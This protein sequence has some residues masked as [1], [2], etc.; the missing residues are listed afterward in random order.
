MA[1][2][3]S[4]PLE[5]EEEY[6]G[7]L[8]NLQN[9][10]AEDD[11][12]DDDDDGDE[13]VDP[14]LGT[15]S[16]TDPQQQISSLEEHLSKVT[17][18]LTVIRQERDKQRL[19]LDPLTKENQALM[20]QRELRLERIKLQEQL[21][22]LQ[23]V[24]DA[25]LL[26]QKVELEGLE[27]VKSR[28]RQLQ[29][30]LKLMQ[31]SVEQ[32]LEQSASDTSTS[33]EDRNKA[34]MRQALLKQMLQQDWRSQLSL[35]HDEIHDDGDDGGGPQRFYQKKQRYD[36]INSMMSE[37]A[38]SPSQDTM[39]PDSRRSSPMIRQYPSTTTS[40]SEGRSLSRS[41][42]YQ[43]QEHQPQRHPSVSRSRSMS[44]HGSSASGSGK[45]RRRRSNS[46]ERSTGSLR[47]SKSFDAASQ[48]SSNTSTSTG[49][50]RRKTALMSLLDQD[51]KIHGD[52]DEG[53]ADTPKTTNN[54]GTR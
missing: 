45:S 12:Q 46:G 30:T 9:D 52:D 14:D 1:S 17:L 19:Q 47:R 20:N 32:I 4:V 8:S 7:V 28:F 44:S 48:A 16:L 26:V 36:S 22:E 54:Q 42:F 13:E 11:L 37:L 3:S 33:L 53:S 34:T 43:E 38:N 31:G 41:K 29:R 49:G 39:V 23:G 51:G 5:G 15:V 2:S 27:Q 10:L 21:N 40:S 25:K 35:Y 24:I 6:R 50:S 18:E